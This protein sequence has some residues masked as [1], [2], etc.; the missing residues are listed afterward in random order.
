MIEAFGQFGAG[1]FLGIMI[2]L[3]VGMGMLP[4]TCWIEDLRKKQRI[5]R[6]ESKKKEYL[7]LKEWYDNL[8]GATK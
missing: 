2:G 6:I 4:F 5:M 1:I 7:R 3:F 8:E